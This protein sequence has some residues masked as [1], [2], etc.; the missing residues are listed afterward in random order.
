METNTSNCVRCGVLQ[1]HGDIPCVDPRCPH[2][3]D[4]GADPDRPEPGGEY[5]PL[6]NPDLDAWEAQVFGNAAPTLP[7]EEETK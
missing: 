1:V 7:N 2:L 3:N 4:N 5:H 6:D